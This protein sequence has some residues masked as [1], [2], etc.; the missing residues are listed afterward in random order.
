MYHKTDCF[1][2]WKQFADSLNRKSISNFW[3]KPTNQ[4]LFLFFLKKIKR[5]PSRSANIQDIDRVQKL[6]FRKKVSAF[7]VLRKSTLFY[8]KNQKTKNKY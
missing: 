5:P 4:P 1:L 3:S 6:I 2:K 7:R 8:L